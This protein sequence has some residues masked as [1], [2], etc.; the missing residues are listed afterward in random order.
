MKRTIVNMAGALLIMFILFVIVTGWL[1]ES[2]NTIATLKTEI[3]LMKENPPIETITL[4]EDFTLIRTSDDYIYLSSLTINRDIWESATKQ[5]DINGVTWYE[6]M[7]DGY[8]K[9][10]AEGHIPPHEVHWYSPY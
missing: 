8:I 1:I 9:V 7:Q 2:E 5:T 6:I 4:N 10:Y 3:S